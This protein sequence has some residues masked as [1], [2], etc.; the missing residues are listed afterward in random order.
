MLR[1]WSAIRLVGYGHT[2]GAAV[3]MGYARRDDGN[4]INAA[5]LESGRFEIDLAGK[6]LKAKVSLKA[7]FDPSGVRIKL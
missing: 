2:V 5:W 4:A 1:F 6:R 3:G 7:P